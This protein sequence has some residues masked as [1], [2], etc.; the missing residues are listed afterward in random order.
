VAKIS[1]DTSVPLNKCLCAIAQGSQQLGASVALMMAARDVATAM[2]RRGLL[3][4]S[5]PGSIAAGAF[6]FVALQKHVPF[7]MKAIAQAFEVS[8]ATVQKHFKAIQKTSQPEPMPPA[9]K[10]AP[11][12]SGCCAWTAMDGQFAS[13]SVAEAHGSIA[14]KSG[15][16]FK[17]T[18]RRVPAAQPKAQHN[19]QPA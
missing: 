16:L 10:V 17:P 7:T 13:S 14:V 18:Y 12:P 11:V 2:W 9:A 15:Q 5:R 4:G 6:K 3:E 8:T 19:C 1:S